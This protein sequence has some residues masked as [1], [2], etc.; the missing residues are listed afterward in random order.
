MNNVHI[1]DKPGDGAALTQKLLFRQIWLYSNKRSIVSGLPLSQY[2]NTPF[3]FSCFAHILAK[4]MNKYPYY[5]FL[6][7]NI[8]LVSPSEH[9]LYDN[10]TEEQRTRYCSEVK[11][12]NWQPLYDLQEELKQEYKKVFPTTI[13]MMIGYKYSP[14]EV[15]ARVGLMNKKFFEKLVQGESN[16]K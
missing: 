11:T 7:K 4:G 13:G 15:M 12:A 8:A 1:F 16:S 5:K 9:H 2:V 14:E 10:D 6:A 3:F